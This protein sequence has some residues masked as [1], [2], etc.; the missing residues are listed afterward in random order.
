MS[1]R[2]RVPA[3]GTEAR[4]QGRVQSVERALALM[5]A[6]AEDEDGH[7][8]SDLAA[9]TG[10]SLSTVHRLLTTLEGRRF[11]QFDQTH[12]LWHVGRQAFT[13]GSTFVHNRNFVASALPF[14]RWLRDQT[15]ETANLGV[16]DEGEVVMLTQIESLKI[17]C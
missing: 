4:R 15:R 9:R 12:G 2:M 1:G 5:E 13:V 10:L 14:L 17:T 3:Q 8:L 16:V 7:R 11:V 6:L